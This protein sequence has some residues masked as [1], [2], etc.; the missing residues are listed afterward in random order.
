MLRDGRDRH[1]RVA[2]EVDPLSAL[3]DGRDVGRVVDDE[4]EMLARRVRLAPIAP[5]G[6]LHREELVAETRLLDRGEAADASLVAREGDRAVLGVDFGPAA[7]EAA[8]ARAERGARQ[9][10]LFA[11][12]T[13]GH[14]LARRR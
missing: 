10:L 3:R 14:V 13:L 2:V 4:A 8:A 5:R 12:S 6:E 1:A 7:H 11:R 9:S